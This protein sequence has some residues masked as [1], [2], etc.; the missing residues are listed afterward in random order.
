MVFQTITFTS[1]EPFQQLFLGYN[2]TR[3]TRKA[4]STLMPIGNQRVVPH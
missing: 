4:K 1:S 2:L 3:S